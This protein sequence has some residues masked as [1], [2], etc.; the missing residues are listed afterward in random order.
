MAEMPHLV[1]AAVVEAAA[2]LMLLAQ[3]QHQGKDM[4]AEVVITL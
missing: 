1:V 3:T 2:V 4:A